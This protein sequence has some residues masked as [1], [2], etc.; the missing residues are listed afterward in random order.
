[1]TPSNGADY[2]HNGSQTTVDELPVA[3]LSGVRVVEV[4]SYVSGPL[5]TQVLSDL[6][7]EVVKVEP[8]AGDPM[9]NFG[10]R[11]D[12]LS[13]MW[14][15]VNRGK[16]G[17]VVNLKDPDG[18]GQ[19]RQL[20]ATADIF[21]QNWRPGVAESLGLG[22]G[23]LAELNPRLI[24]VSITGFGATGPSK[25][26]PVFDV[27]LQ[28]ASGLAASE[29]ADG[30][31]SS[32]RSL[33]ADKTTALFAANA[34]LAALA[35][36]N[37][38]GLGCRIEM[39]MLD[40]LAYFDFPDLGQDRTFLGEGL[41]QDLRRGRSPLLRTSDGYVAVSPVSGS[42]IGAAV[43]AVGH[44]EWK[45]DLKKIDNPTELTNIL[46]DRLEAETQHRPTA[47]WVAIFEAHDVPA[48]PVMTIDQ[49]LVDEQVLVNQLY[50]EGSSPVG[51]VRQVRYPIRIDGQ[52]LQPPGPAPD[53]G[54]H[55]DEVFAGS[56]W[57][58]PFVGVTG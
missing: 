29:G 36:R 44:P 2:R 48:A 40:V 22:D 42:Q 14:V 33:I 1:M 31:P 12:G 49:H 30:Q 51:P 27:L 50:S 8:P 19:F 24:R 57:A 43:T 3:M 23:D 25:S 10:L 53:L 26:R 46:Y 13:A 28:A 56:W 54:E 4:A 20:L 38:T 32:V 39:A 58:P 37:Q 34:C 41:Q 16:K 52:L 5:A 9:R 55:T 45:N 15:N 17:V 7:A 35:R 6:G 18:M 21:V 11:V 47:E